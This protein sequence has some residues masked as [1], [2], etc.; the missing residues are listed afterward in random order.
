M[1]ERGAAGILNRRMEEERQLKAARAER[2]RRSVAARKGQATRKK[3]AADRAAAEAKAQAEA[4]AAA[5]Q[6]AEEASERA[7][8]RG[9]RI[10][11]AVRGAGSAANYAAQGTPPTGLNDPRLSLWL[12]SATVLTAVL[13]SSGWGKVRDSIAAGVKNK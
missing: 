10:G 12:Y 6:A 2:D 1:S 8:R 5:Q 3:N 9:Q 11:G 7:Y 4:E 13:F